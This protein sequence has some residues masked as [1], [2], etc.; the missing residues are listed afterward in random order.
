MWVLSHY[1]ALSWHNVPSDNVSKN[2]NFIE[3]TKVVIDESMTLGKS[4]F[5]ATT[6]M[7]GKPIRQGFM[8][9]HLADAGS[10]DKTSGFI[11]DTIFAMDIKEL[12]TIYEF[13]DLYKYSN[14]FR[15]F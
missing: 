1:V 9:H 3:P 15:L 4:K 5:I 11:W 10:F 2:P 7:P 14:F 6:R 12:G 8:T 13:C